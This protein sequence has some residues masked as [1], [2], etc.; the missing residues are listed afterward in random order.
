MKKYGSMI[1][2]SN[3]ETG[4]TI[5]KLLKQTNTKRGIDEKGYT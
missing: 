1:I 3:G 2:N 4:E 5:K